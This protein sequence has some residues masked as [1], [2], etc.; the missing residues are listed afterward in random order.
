MF[1]DGGENASL[2]YERDPERHASQT[3]LYQSAFR[4]Q[5]LRDQEHIIHL[6]T[7]TFVDKILRL[8]ED[9]GKVDMSRATEWLTFDIIG[10][11]FVF[12]RACL[13]KITDVP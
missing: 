8:S 3:K 4:L 11:H 2:A 9:N 10:I 5:A 6:H 1:Y 13:Q 7:D 12:E